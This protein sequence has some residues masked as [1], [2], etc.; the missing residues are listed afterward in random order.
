VPSIIKVDQIQSDTGTVNQTSN[1][2][3]TGTGLRIRGDFSTTTLANR[4]A[5]QTS[6]VNSSSIVGVLPNGTSGVSSLRVYQNSDPT[7]ASYGEILAN[8][9]DSIA[10]RSLRH[11][12]GTFLP[13]TFVTGGSERL[14]IPADAGGITFPASQ[15]ASSDP[16]TLDDYEEGTYTPVFRQ[17]GGGTILTYGTQYAL[18]S[19]VG[20]TEA[21]TLAYVKIGRVVY[22]AGAIR[23]KQAGITGRFNLSLPFTVTGSDYGLSGS[24]GMYNFDQTLNQGTFLG[25]AN[26]SVDFFDLGSGNGAHVN[27]TTKNGS[28]IYFNFFYLTST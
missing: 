25:L 23:F 15:A 26:N 7:N 17:N 8:G 5:I 14:R 12:T 16:N 24:T 1:L 4:V 28:E 18:L 21:S 3:F 6:A 27:L 19:A 9:T 10:I 13:M 2:S 22:I 11:G 20:A